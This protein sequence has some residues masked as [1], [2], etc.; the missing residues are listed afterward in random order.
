MSERT[1]WASGGTY[2]MLLLQL[3]LE[4][5]CMS[6]TVTPQLF[7]F[8]F[9][10]QN[11]HCMNQCQL[12]ASQ[13]SL[14]PLPSALATAKSCPLCSLCCNYWPSIQKD[15]NRTRYEQQNTWHLHTFFLLS[16]SL[17]I[18]CNLYL[19]WNST[20]SLKNPS[21][22]DDYAPTHFSLFYAKKPYT[23]FQSWL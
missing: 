19:F 7:F 9:S 17:S 23:R 10:L 16:L 6:V 14:L 13:P 3:R 18:Y 22:I 5:V 21:L 4:F 2:G 8:F 1:C 12:K 11:N 15:P 20:A